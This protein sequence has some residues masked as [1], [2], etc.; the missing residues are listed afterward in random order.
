MGE[1]K[2]KR[3]SRRL[4]ST[5]ID[6]GL[7]LVAKRSEI[8]GVSKDTAKRHAAAIR[9]VVQALGGTRSRVIKPGSWVAL[10]ARSDS[11]STVISNM[12]FAAVIFEWAG[13]QNYND[14][15]FY[16]DIANAIRTALSV[17]G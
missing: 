16:A 7:E 13:H 2:T 11:T 8:E 15:A 6:T 14:A 17:R 4:S 10:Y 1:I 3:E 5:L 12:K 9:G